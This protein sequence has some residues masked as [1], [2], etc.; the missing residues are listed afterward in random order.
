MIANVEAEN[1]V[2]AAMMIDSTIIDR[3]AD[4]V[5]PEDFSDPLLS[6]MFRAS[7]DSHAAGQACGAVAINNMFKD[8]DA[9]RSAG[10]QGFM[11]NLTGS[12]AA[13]IGGIDL[14]KQVADLARRRRITEGLTE[15][16]G[17]AADQSV[18][19][20][21][22]VEAADTALSAAAY[23]SASVS[24]YSAA[25]AIDA[26]LA[27]L[28]SKDKGV[29]CKVIPPMDELLGG[30]RRKQMIILAARPGMGKTAVALSYS[31][32]AAMKGLN[33][34]LTSTR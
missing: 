3:I 26:M 10:G 18:S 7:R 29:T 30:A 8:D 4:I 21:E 6:R 24:H 27:Q 16:I 19:L 2:L 20:S 12:V 5:A 25:G 32:G 28:D 17:M 34:G 33:C 14:A 23:T 11:A 15:V 9:Y 31:I 13:V 1:V 22:A